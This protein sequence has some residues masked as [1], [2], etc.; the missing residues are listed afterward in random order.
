MS[1][2]IGILQHIQAVRGKLQPTLQIVADRILGDP[3]SVQSMNIKDLASACDVS[4]ASISRF[5]RGIG[6]PSYRAFLLRMAELRIDQPRNEEPSEGTIYE[7]IGRRDTAATI[8]TK[9]V[10]RSADVA[11]ACLSTLDSNAL[12]A[13][14]RL[15]GKADVIYLFGAGSSALAAE[16]ALLRFARI[17][18]PAIFHRDRN[19]QMFLAS[20]LHTGALAIAISDSGRTAQTVQALERAKEAGAATIAITSFPDAPLTRHADV[21]LLTPPPYEPSGEEPLYE[22]MVSKIGQM[23]AIDVLYSLAAVHDYERASASVRRGDPIIQQSRSSARR[24]NDAT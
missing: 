22:S 12:E 10:H 8:L 23:V 21:T 20:A 7:N 13:A 16:N 3:A 24:Q 14:A 5:V 2:D 18:K 15:V 4:E 6:L 17:G 19:T 11:R 9:A 1:D